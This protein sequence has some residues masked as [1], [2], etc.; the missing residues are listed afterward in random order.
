MEITEFGFG[1]EMIVC[2]D[3]AMI[4]NDGAHV[5]PNVFFLQDASEEGSGGGSQA[6]RA[7]QAALVTALKGQDSKLHRKGTKEVEVA[8][9]P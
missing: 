6:A 9:A 1:K 5:H 2:L 4:D 8:K 3:A 7:D